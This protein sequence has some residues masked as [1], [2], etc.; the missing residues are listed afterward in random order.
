MGKDADPK[1]YTESDVR[2]LKEHIARLMT[3]FEEQAQRIEELELQVA[4]MQ[5]NSSTSSKPPSSDITKPP[6]GGSSG[7]GKKR[8]PGGQPGH[9]KH[10]REL[11]KPDEVD[12]H[13][14]YTLDEADGLEPIAEDDLDEDAWRIV[15][16]ID[17]TGRGLKIVEH[18]ARRYRCIYTGRIVVAPLPEGVRRGELLSPGMV[19]LVAYLKGACH[20][21]YNNIRYFFKEVMGIELCV[22]LLVKAVTK[23]AD[24]LARPY[25]EVLDALPAQP[26]LGVD[27]TGHRHM[28]QRCWTWCFQ[29]PSTDEEPGFTCFAIDA[30]RGSGVVKDLLGEDYAGVIVCDF[31]SAYRKCWEDMEHVEMQFCWS[32]LI[33]DLK[34]L[35]TLPALIAQKYGERVLKVV[36]RMFDLWHR[37]TELGERYY[38]R[39]MRR[40]KAK[41]LK[42]AKSQSN[43]PEV[44]KLA[45]RLTSRYA[46]SYFTF[47]NYRGV[48]PTNNR[49]EQQ[50]RFVV[51]GRKVIQGTKAE[52]GKQWCERIWTTLATC[53]Q[54]N[55]QLYRFLVES[56]EF[57]LGNRRCYPSLIY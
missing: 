17:W 36:R 19:G 2:F 50:I 21:S 44:R 38:K 5:R 6:K 45:T 4:R 48:D 18:R 52:I 1:L 13:W 26:V 3:A 54:R 11:F 40:A 35:L 12:D 15:Q 31:F 8:K 34:F 37:R 24:A 41:L 30:S 51:I 16:Q 55:K 32:H 25:Q 29:A 33:R 20:L 57:K 10:E 27:E 46:D 39:A 9:K 14:Q 53:R 49:T 22:G 42:E 47:M 56:I 43:H 28:G 23:A 7:G